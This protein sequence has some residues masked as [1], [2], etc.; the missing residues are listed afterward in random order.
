VTIDEL[1]A[2]KKVLAGDKQA[3]RP[4]VEAYSRLVYTS[5]VKIVRDPDTAQ[6]IA[7]ETFLQAFR[8]LASFRSE[9]AF[10]TWL[11]RIA[12]NKALDH[13]RRLKVLPRTEELHDYICQDGPSPET[14]VLRQENIWQMREQIQRLPG[15]YRKVIFDYY[16][17]ES[18]YREIAQREGISVKTV[19]SRLYRAKAMLKESMAGGEGNVSAP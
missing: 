8:S 11:V 10:S 5:V 3:F 17:Q 12:V 7:Q 4:L 1:I 13:C 6:D 18:T 15:I 19:E 16:F 2:I 9:S 14:E